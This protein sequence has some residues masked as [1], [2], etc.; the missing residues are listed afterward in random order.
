MLYVH[1]SGVVVPALHGAQAGGDPAVVAPR[2]RP[3]HPAEHQRAPP[4]A[5][6]RRPLPEPGEAGGGRG[7]GGVGAAEVGGAARGDHLVPGVL[8]D[9]RDHCRGGAT[10]SSS[11]S[12]DYCK[13]IYLNTPGS[14]LK[15]TEFDE[16]LNI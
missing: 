12:S 3:R 15:N 16:Q 9:D 14:Q 13:S 4:P 6:Q 1:W 5:L 10:I 8:G 11:L 2:L 7:G